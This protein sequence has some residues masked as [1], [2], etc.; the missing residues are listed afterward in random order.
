MSEEAITI[1][2][3]VLKDNGLWEIGK[4]PSKCLWSSLN[5]NIIM[6]E[7][8]GPLIIRETSTLY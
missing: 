3:I 5:M 8:L 4:M 2:T 1:K 7:P 6:L